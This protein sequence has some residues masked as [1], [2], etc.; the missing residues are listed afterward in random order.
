MVL[1][2]AVEPRVSSTPQV[3]MG[4]F[5]GS[6]VI[7]P[8]TV[9]V[10]EISTVHGH[11]SVLRPPGTSHILMDSSTNTPFTG[12]LSQLAM[13]ALRASVSQPAIY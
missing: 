11:S 10:M 4:L 13:T 5:P 3:P 9:S 8:D 7:V 2:G 6:A 12:V 1:V